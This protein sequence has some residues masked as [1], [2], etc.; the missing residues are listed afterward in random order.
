MSIL[1]WGKPKIE[2]AAF[3]DGAL[4]STPTWEE[5]EEIK[6]GTAQLETEQGDKVEA[7]EEGGGVV[8]VRFGASKYT[9]T[10]SLFM[11]KGD[12]KPIEDVD[13]VVSTN[14]AL[15][16]TPEDSAALGFMLP[17]CA[18][19]VQETWTSADGGLWTYTFSALKP[20]SGTTLQ[21]YTAPA[22]SGGTP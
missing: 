12:T 17:K 5:L 22:Q 19:S 16:L 3:V 11:K 20:E 4:P 14:Y 13:G 2:V 9:F 18:V 10:F 8:D 15:R 1:S 21:R 6:E 7:L